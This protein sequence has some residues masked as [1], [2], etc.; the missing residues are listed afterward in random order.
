MD[1]EELRRQLAIDEGYSDKPYRCSE[2][3]LTIGYG[4]NLKDKG[5]SQAEGDFL[6]END[7]AE[8]KADL[9]ALPIYRQQDK[10]RRTVLA[11]MCY[12]LGRP[13]LLKF[14]K[15]W[16]ALSLN[17]YELAAKEML[18]SRWARQVG[19]RALRLATIMRTGRWLR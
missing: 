9:E 18:D 11:N 15:M 13:K 14:K 3:K 4:R 8:V 17:D 16:F 7:I 5:I 6:L 10:V 19:D 1:I 12:N 2:G